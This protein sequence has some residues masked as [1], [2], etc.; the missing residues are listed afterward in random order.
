MEVLT[1]TKSFPLALLLIAGLASAPPK[2]PTEV[3]SVVTGGYWDTGKSHGTYRV[4]SWRQGF[5]HVSSGVIAEWIAD[6][7][8]N[9]SDSKVIA[10]K[11]LVEPGL[12]SLG[13]PEFIPTNNSLVVKL[14]GVATHSPDQSVS[15]VFELYPN[16]VVKTVRQC[17]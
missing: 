3:S 9:N 17:Q 1:T 4:V 7:I 8:D 10:T 6:P 2:V 13:A 15:C 12:F 11:Q 14:S 5:E 16:A